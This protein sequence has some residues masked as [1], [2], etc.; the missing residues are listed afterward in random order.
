MNY[1][2]ELILSSTYEELNRLEVFLNTLQTDLNFD[3]EFYARLMLTVSEAATN[4][5]VHGNKLDED[6]RVHITA[7]CDGQ[8]L[9]VTTQD[10]GEGF[11]P[12][13]VK[14]PLDEENLLKA[15]GRGVF[16]MGEYADL[17]TYEDSGKRLIMEFQLP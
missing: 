8:R 5:V 1:T 15:S 12:Q 4:G 7:F 10:E 3:D 6:K 13:S 9:V 17:V 14:N 16:L 11:D 2:H